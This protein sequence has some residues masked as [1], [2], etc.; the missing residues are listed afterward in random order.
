MFLG[1]WAGTFMVLIAAV[2]IATGIR[3][4]DSLGLVC[5]SVY[6]LT[7]LLWILIDPKKLNPK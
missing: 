6:G 3:R 5:G 7:A 4:H 2:S 1:R